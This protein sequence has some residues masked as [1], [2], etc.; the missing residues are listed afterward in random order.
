MTPD[1][2][3]LIKACFAG[4]DVLI[5]RALRQN[6]EFLTLCEDY[7]ACSAALAYWKSCASADATL[8]RREYADLLVDLDR[9]I[10]R[11]LEALETDEAEP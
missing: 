10:Q 2:M 3:S 5:E 1:T 7:H 11:W 6:A 8:R 4:R 9:E